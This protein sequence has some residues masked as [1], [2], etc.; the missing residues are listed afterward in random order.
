MEGAT[1]MLNQITQMREE[2]AAVSE[3]DLLKEIAELYFK[4]VKEF[5]Y[6]GFTR[7]EAVMITAQMMLD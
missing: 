7:E 6:A 4:T 5:E 2:I 3:S 1:D